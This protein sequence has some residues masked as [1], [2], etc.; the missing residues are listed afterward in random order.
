MTETTPKAHDIVVGI[1]GSAGSDHALDWAIAEAARTARGITLVHALRPMSPNERAWLLRGGVV[2]AQMQR[3]AQHDAELMLQERE[4][5]VTERAPGAHVTTVVREEDPRV[6]LA[7]LSQQA[8]LVVVGSRGHGTVGSILLGSVSQAVTRTADCPVVVI[9]PPSSPATEP[10]VVVGLSTVPESH[11]TLAAGFAE[12]ASRGVPLVIVLCVW[13]GYSAV[14]GWEELSGD[15][16][17]LTEFQV[18]VADAV[19]QLAR[20]HPGVVHTTVLAQG[21][22]DRCFLDLSRSRDLLVV[23]RHG[24]HALWGV[25]ALGSLATTV[26]EHAHV[27]VMVVP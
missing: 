6:A 1:D 26:V 20:E 2:P 16:P 11:P 23:G 7:E 19:D 15:S 14:A 3:D 10:G 21:S 18:A 27:P 4:K 22:V 25:A 12:A 24:A 8:S 17:E 9:R 5:L 13:D